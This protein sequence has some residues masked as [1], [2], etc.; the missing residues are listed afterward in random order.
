MPDP[1][2]DAMFI[3]HLVVEYADLLKKNREPNLMEFLERLPP[4]LQRYRS[5]VMRALLTQEMSYLTA[6]QNGRAP[7]RAQV[8]ALHSDVAA[9]ITSSVFDS[10]RNRSESAPLILDNKYLVEETIDRGGEA[11]IAR[12]TP[13][14][15][16]KPVILK[17]YHESTPNRS[18]MRERSALLRLVNAPDELIVKLLDDGEDAGY[19]YLVL[20]YCSCAPLTQTFSE[21]PPSLSDSL[22]ICEQLCRALQFCHEHS[23]F[24]GDVTPRNVLADKGAG[25]KLIDFGFS[26]IAA[27][28]LQSS[29]WVQ[30]Y[31]GTFDFMSPEKAQATND[32]HVK[33][34]DIFGIGAVLYWLLTQQAP[35]QGP[36]DSPR[37]EDA[38]KRAAQNHLISLQPLERPRQRCPELVELCLRLMA[39]LP[40]DR[41]STIEAI[42]SN[43]EMIK[44]AQQRTL[45]GHHESSPSQLPNPAE[46]RYRLSRLRSL[47][48]RMKLNRSV[49]D[50]LYRPVQR[51]RREIVRLAPSVPFIDSGIPLMQIHCG[52]ILLFAPTDCEF[53]SDQQLADPTT[54]TLN[55]PFSSVPQELEDLAITPQLCSRAEFVQAVE[56]WVAE[57]ESTA[58]DQIRQLA[59]RHDKRLK[60]YDVH[61][62]WRERRATHL[63]RVRRHE[64]KIR[65]TVTLLSVIILYFFITVQLILLS[66][67][68]MTP[69]ETLEEF[70]WPILAVVVM[71]AGTFFMISKSVVDGY[72][73]I[74]K[75]LPPRDHPF[76]FLDNCDGRFA[77]RLIPAWSNVKSWWQ[78]P[79]GRIQH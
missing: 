37:N 29:L 65:I 66:Q 63:F 13:L 68:E 55:I 43:V 30:E 9:E 7:T 32:V 10:L 33:A 54:V 35:F 59:A 74:L 22:R 61:R 39:K 71:G 3:Q 60:R 1:Y 45:W 72:E 11:W 23:V 18:Q 57:L 70:K 51:D 26:T 52:E 49:W 62:R 19:R 36:A 53:F 44:Q 2:E 25:F 6:I 16:G 8:I 14:P 21:V 20:E 40:Q 77:R 79:G 17:I 4:R 73:G 28:Y 42:L 76:H 67:P 50:D 27:D 24:H 56:D 15:L 34:D 75:L 48:F 69:D 31:S 64:L 41:P 46:S 5:D 78:R 58:T 47:Q 38:I 12:A